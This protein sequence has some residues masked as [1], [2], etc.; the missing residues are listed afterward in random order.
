MPLIGAHWLKPGPINQ[1]DWLIEPN[2]FI[3]TFQSGYQSVQVKLS[4][5][6]SVN[7]DNVLEGIPLML[8]L[9]TS[10]PYHWTHWKQM[11]NPPGSPLLPSTLTPDA[12]D[13]P[14]TA[15]DPQV[16]HAI[17]HSLV[18]TNI[19]IPLFRTLFHLMS[20]SS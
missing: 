17:H 5:N 16:P 8:R 10:S 4:V 9:P 3:I 20:C 13:A 2:P 1:L 7:C 11:F 6:C 14:D 15:D 12:P 18:T 19:L